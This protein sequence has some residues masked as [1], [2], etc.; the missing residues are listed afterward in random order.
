M[1][2]HGID[3]VATHIERFGDDDANRVRLDRLRR[4]A[5]GRMVPTQYDLNFYAHELREFV[6]YR[7]AGFPAGA[8]DDY[9]LW[10]NT[11]SATL[12]DYRLQELGIHGNRNLFHPDAW[13]FFP[14]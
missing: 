11:H 13:P 5:N 1:T 6:R 7:R 8:G 12:L 10:N 4:I 3:R 9:S 2:H 14:R